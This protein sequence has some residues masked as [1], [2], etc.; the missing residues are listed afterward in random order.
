VPPVREWAGGALSGEKQVTS[1]NLN[2]LA[3]QAWKDGR[4]DSVKLAH[5][6]AQRRGKPCNLTIVYRSR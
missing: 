4:G 6:A 1:D 3:L 2:E 5:A